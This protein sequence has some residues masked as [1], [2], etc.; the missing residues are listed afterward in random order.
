MITQQLDGWQAMLAVRT[1]PWEAIC[2]TQTERCPV[3]VKHIASH[4]GVL[5]AN[6]YNLTL[7]KYAPII[8]EIN[9][10]SGRGVVE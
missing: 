3:C 7:L 6:M 1:P 4:S 5:I 8:I 9:C 2:F 10:G